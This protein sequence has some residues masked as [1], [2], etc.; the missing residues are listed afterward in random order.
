MPPFLL[1]LLVVI[2]GAA[3][4]MA[5]KPAAKTMTPE[6]Q[7]LF[8]RII[9]SERDPAKLRSF[10]GEFRKEGLSFQADFLD[11][12]AKL[13]ELPPQVK[14]QRRAAFK[15]AM[16]SK[17]KAKVLALADMYEKEASTGAAEKL[18]EYAKGL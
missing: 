11:K 5:K 10:A 4:L 8:Q 18:R 12:R 14:A 3:F 1:P 2:G 6:R 15:A 7:M 9:A 13:R 17:D 16:S